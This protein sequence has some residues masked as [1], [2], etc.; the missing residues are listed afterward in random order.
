MERRA[1]DRP[2][3]GTLTRTSYDTVCVRVARRGGG[4]EVDLMRL[5]GWK[6]WAM[7][8]RYGAAVAHERAIDAHRK[9]SPGDRI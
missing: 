5:A 3:L 6:S 2:G 8:A 9:L 1:C 7:V 4:G